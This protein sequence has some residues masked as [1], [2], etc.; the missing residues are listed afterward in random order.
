MYG[1]SWIF[2]CLPDAPCP[3]SWL[4]NDILVRSYNTATCMACISNL[5]PHFVLALSQIIQEP[6]VDPSSKTVSDVSLQAFAFRSREL[7]RLKSRVMVT[8][9]QVLLT[10]SPPSE[11][12]HHTLHSLPVFPG[13]MFGPA[14]Q[15]TLEHNAQT[16][17]TICKF[18]EGPAQV[19]KKS[20]VPPLDPSNQQAAF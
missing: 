9:H 19:P 5:F 14:T 17:Q 8:C 10:E 6:G 12:C 1:P 3:Q 15:Q 16:G 2:H 20:V 4:A 18:V 11:A 13:Q 7:L